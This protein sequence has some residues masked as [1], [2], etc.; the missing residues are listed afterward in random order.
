[1][2]EAPPRLG[3]G[4]SVQQRCSHEVRI[5]TL[6]T[7][8]AGTDNELRLPCVAAVGVMAAHCSP[9]GFSDGLAHGCVTSSPRWLVSGHAERPATVRV[10]RGVSGH[11]E[12]LIRSQIDNGGQ[13]H[14][15]QSVLRSAAFSALPCAFV[16]GRVSFPNRCA[17]NQSALSFGL[18]SKE[19]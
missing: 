3:G 11:T 12:A 16:S 2:S 4:A 19:H 7:V 13:R 17:A 6:S 9:V 10:R 14:A 15:G 18:A 8:R 5:G 1:M